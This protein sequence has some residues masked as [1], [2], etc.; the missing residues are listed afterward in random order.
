MADR[1]RIRANTLYERFSLLVLLDK[2]VCVDRGF[3]LLQFLEELKVVSPNHL[4][5]LFGLLNI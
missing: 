5:S 3:K 1:Q 4:V 2:L